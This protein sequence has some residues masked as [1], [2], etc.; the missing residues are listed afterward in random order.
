MNYI[1]MFVEETQSKMREKNKSVDESLVL[2][3]AFRSCNLDDMNESH[4]KT[5]KRMN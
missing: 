2:K 5:L 4:L 1:H 3:I